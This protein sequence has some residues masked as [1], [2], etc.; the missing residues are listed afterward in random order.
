MKAF[1]DKAIDTELNRVMKRLDKLHHIL[2]N[3][4]EWYWAAIDVNL[5]HK[6]RTGM[7]C[8]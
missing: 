7:D 2:W 3:H 4:R 6:P 1:T 5:R 8:S